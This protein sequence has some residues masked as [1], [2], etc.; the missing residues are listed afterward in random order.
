MRIN[1]KKTLGLGALAAASVF[2]TQLLYGQREGAP[3]QTVVSAAT[4]PPAPQTLAGIAGQTPIL[5]LALSRTT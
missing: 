5:P 4:Q 1:L 3:P 2:S